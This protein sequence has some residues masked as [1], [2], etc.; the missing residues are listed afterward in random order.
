[1]S[2]H[3]YALKLRVLEQPHRY[4]A[5]EAEAEENRT[6]VPV[7]LPPGAELVLGY[8]IDD[9]RRKARRIA[10]VDLGRIVRGM[11]I[12]PDPRDPK[13]ASGITVVVFKAEERVGT[14]TMKESD[15]KYPAAGG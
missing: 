2:R 1:M 14:K 6:L 4:P 12:Q 15:R 11:S 3:R 8:N 10:E 5:T 7:E 13:K 9:C